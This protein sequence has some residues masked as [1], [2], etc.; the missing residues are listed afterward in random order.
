MPSS[1]ATRDPRV[2]PRRQ[3]AHGLLLADTDRERRVGAAAWVDR[4]LRTGAKV[5]YKGWLTDGDDDPQN[6]WLLG[7]GG[8]P[9][10]R[11][12][13]ESGQLEIVGFPEVVARC[14]GTTEGLHALLSGEVERAVRQGFARVAMSQESARR[15]MVDE[16]EAAEF[17]AQESAY[18]DLARRWP[19]TTLCQHNVAEE[20][21]A[22]TWESA[23]LHHHQLLDPQ[24]SASLS[25]RRWYLRG[26]LDAHVTERFG[27]A[28]YGALREA[29]AAGDGPD[30]H[31]DLSGV[32]FADLA[33]AQTLFLTAHSVAAEQRVVLHGASAFL[34]RLFETVG[35]PRSVLLVAD[36]D[37]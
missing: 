17:A 29:H 33:F 3:G 31:V 27:A 2:R 8:A 6:H 34:H 12:A 16:A 37:R 32:E 28:L 4:Q 24:W 22:A 11:D 35:R 18:D 20:N 21:A 10:A 26:T 25:R 13:S 19:L 15:P 23:A 1:T 36:G 30:L 7:R 9:T 14:G 5:Y